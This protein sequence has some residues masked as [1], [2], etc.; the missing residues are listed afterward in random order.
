MTVM[1]IV[2]FG[3]QK[4]KV[5]L[6]EGFTLVLYKGELGKYRI[7]QGE[8]LREE[9]YKEIL[10][11]VLM[12]RARERVIYLLKASDKTEQELRQKLKEGYYP[13]EAIDYAIGFLKE[14]KYIDDER[15]GE[16]YVE[17][18]SERKSRRQIQYELQKKGL[19]KE[20]IS[21]ILEEHPIDEEAQI[22]AYLEKKRKNISELDQKER[23]KIMAA[24]GRKG[25]SFEVVNRVLG[26]V[27]EDS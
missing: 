2:P 26:S 14:Y 25:F 23:S 7:R 21:D 12:K 4:S 22:L 8:E 17:F 11:E 19:D 1:E 9:T 24:L 18:H 16:R 27:S 20:V 5:I 6:D 13:Q 15:Y 10:T 3:K